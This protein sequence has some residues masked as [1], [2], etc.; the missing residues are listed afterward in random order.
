[1]SQ[2]AIAYEHVET[3]DC[4]CVIAPQC[5]REV[6]RRRMLSLEAIAGHSPPY[7]R[8]LLAAIE[9]GEPGRCVTADVIRAYERAMGTTM[10]TEVATL[11]HDYL[12]A[13]VFT[14][15][16]RSRLQSARDLLRP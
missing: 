4:E 7:P 3:E 12:Q 13:T 14:E 9:R 15:E 1:M 16:M 10:E 11:V 6:R 8:D 5:L 2:H